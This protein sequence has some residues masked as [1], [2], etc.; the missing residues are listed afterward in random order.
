MALYGCSRCDVTFYFSFPADISSIRLYGSFAMDGAVQSFPPFSVGVQNDTIVTYDPVNGVELFSQMGDSSYLI[1]LQTSISFVGSLTL[2][3]TA[4]VPTTS[5]ETTLLINEIQFRD[6]NQILNTLTQ[7]LD[8]ANNFIANTIP[9]NGPPPPTQ[10]PPP[11]TQ[12][13]PPPTQPPPPPPPP[14]QPPPPPTEITDIYIFPTFFETLPPPSADP[15]TDD[16]FNL[17][18]PSSVLSLVLSILCVSI[19][20]C[21][22]LIVT[23]CWVFLTKYKLR[24]DTI[25]KEVTKYRITQEL[26]AKNTTLNLN[27]CQLS[28][29][30]NPNTF[31]R[32]N[33]LV[34]PPTFGTELTPPMVPYRSENWVPD[35]EIY[36]RIPAETFQ[37]EMNTY[38][39]PN[40]KQPTGQTMGAFPISDS[41][42]N[43]I[44]MREDSYMAMAPSK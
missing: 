35:S 31:N 16:L 21:S 25:K 23:I 2:E 34:I 14:T 5:V 41:S 38:I 10:P 29:F 28:D 17:S 36:E 1:E 6:G 18:Y 42:H 40:N 37:Q 22:L 32:K 12:P 4:F 30:P 15:L 43:L 20:C 33:D 26:L 24:Y 7:Q 8:F 44:P 3:L 27:S 39:S 19:S 11:P 9:T 13:P